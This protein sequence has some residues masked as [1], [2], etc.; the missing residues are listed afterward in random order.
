MSILT[1]FYTKISGTLNEWEV[2][3]SDLILHDK[4]IGRFGIVTVQQGQKHFFKSDKRLHYHKTV[5]DVP[6][7]SVNYLTTLCSLLLPYGK[8]GHFVNRQIFKRTYKQEFITKQY[9]PL[10][11]FS[12]TFIGNLTDFPCSDII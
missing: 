8:T 6:S 3:I 4:P 12:A 10:S 5:N 1:K 9:M 11:C 7:H 2:P